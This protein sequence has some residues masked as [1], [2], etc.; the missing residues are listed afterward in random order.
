MVRRVCSF[1]EA[2]QKFAIQRSKTSRKREYCFQICSMINKKKNSGESWQ[3]KPLSGN[4]M[5]KM[6]A[7]DPL[8]N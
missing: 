4:R 1:S 8:I 5:K 7:Y 6:E 2:R 3:E